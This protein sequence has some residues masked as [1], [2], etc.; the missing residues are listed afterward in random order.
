MNVK[1]GDQVTAP[2]PGAVGTAPPSGL[3]RRRHS[4]RFQL[5]VANAAIMFLLLLLQILIYLIVTRGQV[6]D[7]VRLN[8]NLV[9][10]VGRNADVVY[11]DTV[12]RINIVTMNERLQDLLKE[13]PVG[14]DSENHRDNR[15]I[16]SLV[17]ERFLSPDTANAIYIRDRRGRQRLYWRRMHGQNVTAPVFDF[18]TLEIPTTGRVRAEMHGGQLVFVRRI[19]S[20]DHYDYVG[21]LALVYNTPKLRTLLADLAQETTR[22]LTIYD[23]AGTLIV[24]TVPAARATPLEDTP[25]PRKRTSLWGFGSEPMISRYHSEA[26]GWTMVSA[27]SYAAVTRHARTILNYLMLG[28]AA[29]WLLGF[30]LIRATADRITGPLRHMVQVSRTED[31]AYRQRYEVTTNN[32]LG[33]LA[34]TLNA[35]MARTNTLVN[36][37]LR[38]E[39][40]YRDM[41]LQALQ[42]QINPH[43]LNNTLECINWLAE[44]ERKDDIRRVTVAFSHIMDALAD[45]RRVVTLED[46]LELVRDFVGIYEILLLG[47]FTYAADVDASLLDL[48]MPRLILQPLVENAVIHGIRGTDGP[49][50]VD[51]TVAVTEEEAGTPRRLQITVADD[52][53]GMPDHVAAAINDYAWRSQKRHGTSGERP[54]PEGEGEG[55]PGD[56]PATQ[57]DSAKDV[58]RDYLP[59]DQNMTATDPMPEPTTHTDIGTGLRNVI[60]RLNLY[61]DGR[62]S[63]HVLSAEGAGSV[64]ELE[65]PLDEE[66]HGDA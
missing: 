36:Q 20:L 46:E 1:H 66:G 65:L 32:E 35:L 6:A 2:S 41:Q 3:P 40:K 15:E 12:S 19:L 23:E 42:S 10:A 17:N 18:D 39:I 14:A 52:G 28:T 61:Y 33:V 22:E 45:Q 63:F 8:D 55:S 5:I 56:F 37:V 47:Q 27:I 60:D 4:L 30:F 16:R 43:M 38:D 57:D 54:V 51:L 59:G 31:E 34:E 48:P 64:V 58:R 44:L 50:Q 25:A 7:A 21:D 26:T 62:A 53:R 11:Q 9:N 49:A 13:D 24:S 29:V